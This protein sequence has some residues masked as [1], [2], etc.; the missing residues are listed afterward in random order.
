MTVPGVAHCPLGGLLEPRKYKG[1]VPAVRPAPSTR[2]RRPAAFA[3]GLVELQ[4]RRVGVGPHQSSVRRCPPDAA[5]DLPAT[6]QR[7]EVH[8]RRRFWPGKWAF[9]AQICRERVGLTGYDDACAPATTAAIDYRDRR[10]CQLLA[11]VRYRPKLVA[12]GAP[13]ILRN[14]PSPEN[15]FNLFNLMRFLLDLFVAL[16]IILNLIRRIPNRL[17]GPIQ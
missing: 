4:Y 15:L 5:S 11:L 17:V 13:S 1:F 3:I 8:D 14:R 10:R 2:P 7:R 16:I 12:D 6:I 9:V